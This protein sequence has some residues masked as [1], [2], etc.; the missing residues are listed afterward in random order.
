MTREVIQCGGFFVFILQYLARILNHRT[1]CDSMRLP[2][3]S[4]TF[5]FLSTR[6]ACLE[7]T[8][9]SNKEVAL[10]FL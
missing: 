1:P 8:R 5:A 2:H 3:S 9:P 6:I 4:M 7:E 10:S